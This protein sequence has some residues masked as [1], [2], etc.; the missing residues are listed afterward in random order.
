MNQM[1]A[2]TALKTKAKDTAQAVF[3]HYQCFPWKKT[4][5]QE[6]EAISSSKDTVISSGT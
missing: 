3:T 1:V 4:P 2:Y 6:A 5:A